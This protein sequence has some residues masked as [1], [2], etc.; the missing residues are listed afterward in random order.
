MSA[1]RGGWPL[2]RFAGVGGVNTAVHYGVYIGLSA[3]MSVLSAHVAATVTA[4]GCSYLL[5]CRFTFGVAP[6]AR[7]L[8]RYPL[9]HLGDLVAGTAAMAVLTRTAEI[10]ARVAT[11]AA[12]VVA[13]PATFLIT[14]AVLTR[15]ARG[16][17]RLR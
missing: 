4:M 7:S 17:G 15:G 10:D 13:M 3:V 9:S 2:L 1:N 6:S 11:V 12:G 14:R 5:N 8:L 16:D